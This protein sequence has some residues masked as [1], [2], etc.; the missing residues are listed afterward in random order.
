MIQD[1]KN[2]PSRFKSSKIVRSLKPPLSRKIKHKSPI[3]K[4]G[5]F[6]LIELLIIIGI[7][8][9]LT[10]I[11]VPAFRSF[12]KESDLKN[13]TQEI[14]NILRLAQSQALASKRNRPWGVWFS[15][16]T[17]PQQYTLFEGQ[18]YSLRVISSDETYKLPDTVEAY[19]ISLVGDSPEIIFNQ[20]VGTTNQ[21]GSISLRLKDDISK[22]KQVIVKSSGKII[23]EAEADPSDENRAKDSRHI[24]FDYSRQIATSSEIL[25]LT[26][27]YNGSSQTEN[28]VI[29]DNLK[30]GQI[31]WKEKVEVDGEN[32]ELKIHTLRLNDLL[33]GTQFCIH[34][35]KRYNTKALKMEISGDSGG[36]LIQYT[37]E[38]QTTQGTSIYA[39]SPIWQ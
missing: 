34:R 25:E 28:I 8:V 24:H 36:D 11:A 2:T 31:Y 37:A 33:L 6:T 15:T 32:Q 27:T 12:Q 30:D 19:E 23:S 16:S 26:F 5:A 22:T 29:A 35:D 39:L 38:G 18:N 10:A 14:I 17:I 7:L 3:R 1:I 21:P 4:G 13:T 9:I 20:I